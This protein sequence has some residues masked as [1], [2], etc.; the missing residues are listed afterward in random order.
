MRFAAEILDTWNMTVK[1]VPGT[2]TL[3]GRTDDFFGE[4]DGR[5]IELPEKPY[6]AIRLKRLNE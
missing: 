3:A 5:S 6:M 2:F 4:K 1:T